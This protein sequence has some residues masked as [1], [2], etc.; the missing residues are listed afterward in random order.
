LLSFAARFAIAE[1]PLKMLGD[2]LWTTLWR[3]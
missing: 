2:V 3:L 1:E